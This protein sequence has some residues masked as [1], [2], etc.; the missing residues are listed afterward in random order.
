MIPRGFPTDFHS[1]LSTG[2]VLMHVAGACA[3]GAAA[4]ARR[5]A[6]G[7]TAHT[8]R[9]PMV[10]PRLY[11]TEWNIF[12]YPPLLELNPIILVHFYQ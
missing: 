6:V 8:R 5:R 7:T 9:R 1:Y 10:A 11:H 12:A 3:A 4:H 2:P